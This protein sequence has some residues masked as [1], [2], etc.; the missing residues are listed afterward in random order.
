MQVN[1][2]KIIEQFKFLFDNNEENKV[3]RTKTKLLYKEAFDKVEMRRAEREINPN[4]TKLMQKYI[5]E[6]N[7]SK[8]N[9]SINPNKNN[10]KN[11]NSDNSNSNLSS[12]YEHKSHL[13]KSSSRSSFKSSFR[14][15]NSRSQ[16]LEK[17]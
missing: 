1:Q 11:N 3:P 5:S 7:V 13:E 16:S 12:I 17:K 9:D 8:Y 10:K 4:K 15:D 2:N 6:N 14:S